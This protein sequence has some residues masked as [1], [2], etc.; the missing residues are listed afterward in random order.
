MRRY[1]TPLPGLLA[2]AM[3]SAFNQAITLDPA[4][5][6]RL[7]DLDGKAVKLVLD[8]VGI[9]LYFIGQGSRLAVLAESEIEPDTII[10]GS[11]TALLAMAVPDWRAPGSGVRIEG[12][13]GSAQALEKLFK[14][15]DPDWEALLSL[16]LGD[17]IGHQVWR[18]LRDTGGMARHGARTAG[19]QL[20]R[21]LREESGLLVTREEVEVFNREVDELREASDRLEARLRRAGLA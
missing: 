16:H 5:G 7:K 2:R 9:D 17:V 6:T 11:P 19:D 13:A 8:R 1:L 10:K 14:Q 21:Y 3:E 12:D 20:A 4:A 15:L 18:M